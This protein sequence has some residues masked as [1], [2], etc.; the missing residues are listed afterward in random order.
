MNNRKHINKNRF[1]IWTLV[2]ALCAVSGIQ[3][4]YSQAVAS[5]ESNELLMGNRMKLTISVPLPSD[6]AKVEFPLLQQAIS[7]KKK[8]VPLLNDTIELLTAYT[9]SLDKVDN[10]AVMKYNLQIQA[11]DSGRYEL[12]PLDFIVGKEKISTRPVPL[13]V[14]PVKAKADDPLDIA[15]NVAEPF[16]V[17]P[18]PEEMEEANATLWWLIALAVIVAGFIIF[19]YLRYRKTGSLLLISKPLPPYQL[20]L[21]RLRK[22][23]QQNLPQ[24]GKTKE[25]YTKLTDILRSYMNRQF[26]IKT[27]E[28]TTAEI[29]RQVSDD[30]ILSKY[31]GVLNSIFETAD[32]VKF[33]KVNPSVVENSRCLTD[34]ERFIE[35]SHPEDDKTLRKGGEK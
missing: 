10:K 19:M 22:L 18:N 33:A 26:R 3:S 6:T 20:A 4:V 32:F 8:Y 14:I 29:L 7:Q 1:F 28:K 34:A 2:L 35:A 15:I 27:F 21:N 24:K 12:P 13:S 11:F 9:K 5:L 31:E 30:E 17:N 16:E 25:Y 23:Q